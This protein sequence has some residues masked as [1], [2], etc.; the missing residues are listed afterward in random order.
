MAINDRFD[1]PAVLNDDGTG[2]FSVQCNATAPTLGFVIGNQ[3]FYHDGRD[4]I[5]PLRGDQCQSGMAATIPE[6]GIALNFLGD[7]FLKNVVAVFDFGKDEMRFAARVA[8]DA[9]SGNG[10]VATGAPAAAVSV[11][12]MGSAYAVPNM[13]VMMAFACALWV[14]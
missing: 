7:V 5:V 13:V 12:S 14:L 9:G 8:D 3:T 6:E 4:L 11:S 2:I 10:S 1:P